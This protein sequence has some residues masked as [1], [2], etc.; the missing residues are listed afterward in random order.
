MAIST[1][2]ETKILDRIC[3]GLTSKMSLAAPE[4]YPV[5]VP[6]YIESQPEKVLQVAWG[7]INP[8]G[9]GE[10]AQGGEEMIKRGQII[11]AIY[12]RTNM[13]PHLKGR[14]LL[15]NGSKGMLKISMA[16]WDA[17]K[18]TYLGSSVLV[19]PMWYAGES[20][21][22]WVTPEENVAKREMYWEVAWAA[23]LPST[24]TMVESDFT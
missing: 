21:T 22:S 7:P 3:Q 2:I 17:L 4:I 18:H 5:V 9:S 23:D 14:Q 20:A 19:E 12:L 24:L 11:I 16:V 6:Q 15:M 10:G 1:D 8:Y 13:D